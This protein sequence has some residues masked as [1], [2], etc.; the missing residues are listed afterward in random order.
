[1]HASVSSC[2]VSSVVRGERN[3]EWG[4][5]GKV[6]SEGRGRIAV[7]GGGGSWDDKS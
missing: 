2:D 1:M 3:L 5:R 7:L 4:K 6:G